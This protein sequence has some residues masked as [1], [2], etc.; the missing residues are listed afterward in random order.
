MCMGLGL[1][2]CEQ[3]QRSQGKASDPFKGRWEE[4][5]GT[6]SRSAMKKQVYLSAGLLKYF[7]LMVRR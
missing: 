6:R 4:F 7:F 1:G 5:E 3:S 2:G